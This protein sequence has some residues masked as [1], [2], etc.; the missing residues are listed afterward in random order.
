[1]EEW[2]M[3]EWMEEVN[4]RVREFFEFIIWDGVRRFE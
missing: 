1:M 3:I 2:I 4:V